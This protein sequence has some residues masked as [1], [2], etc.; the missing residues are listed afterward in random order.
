MP[1]SRRDL[2]RLGVELPDTCGAELRGI[3]FCDERY[4]VSSS[5]RSW[6]GLG[7]RRTVLHQLLVEHAS[8]AG[9]RLA[10]KTHVAVRAGYPITLNGEPTKYK[11]LI[12]ADGQSS[13][14]RTWAGLDG[15]SLFTR[16]VAFRVHYRIHP[17]SPYV[18]IHWGPAGQAYVTPVAE[19]EICVSVMTRFADGAR[20]RDLI[21]SI[22]VLRE[23]L[24]GAE[25]ITPERGA[26]TTT[27]RLR[28]VTR[29]NVALLGDASGS[30]D[31]ITG[32]GMAMSFRQA[33]Q[34]AGAIN[35]GDLSIYER[36]HPSIM[37]L[38]QGMAR[39]MLL[40]DRWPALRHRAL[41]VL[42]HDPATFRTMLRVH[43]GEEPL[44]QFLMRQAPGFG[45]RLLLPSFV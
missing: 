43:I 38:P 29:G 37:R 8:A 6:P 31:A 12:G 9:A 2:A 28:R 7:V 24:K 13:R 1:D 18:E 15:G 5:F 30:A 39:F 34:L 35:A 10:W 23:H 27:R 41:D 22:P 25:V 14:V 4:S 20:S 40:M 44:H 21:E 17:W 19:N 32:E 36:R 45:L 42:A 3:R 26:I 11:F 16:R 33:L